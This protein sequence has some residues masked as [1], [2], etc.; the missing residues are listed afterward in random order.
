MSALFNIE[1]HSLEE[2]AECWAHLIK[3]GWKWCGT[4]PTFP[5]D[6]F[7]TNKLRTDLLF[8]VIYGDNRVFFGH[9]PQPRKTITSEEFLKDPELHLV[10]AQLET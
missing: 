5:R 9:I 6:Y 4:T 8:L 1:C 2:G 7:L 3:Y 10:L